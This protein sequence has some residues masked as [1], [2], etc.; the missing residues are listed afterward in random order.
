ME[1]DPAEN[2]CDGELGEVVVPPPLRNITVDVQLS[3]LW[4][5]RVDLYGLRQLR[6]IA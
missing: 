5:L 2:I 6:V 4:E 1:D 3:L